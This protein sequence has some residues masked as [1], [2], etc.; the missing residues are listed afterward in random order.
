MLYIIVKCANV[1]NINVYASVS[2]KEWRYY[3]C[4]QLHVV[5]SQMSEKVAHAKN[6]IYYTYLH[7]YAYTSPP[8]YMIEIILK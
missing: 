1:Y 2:E 8:L 6:E 5:H 3:V 7:T 4:T